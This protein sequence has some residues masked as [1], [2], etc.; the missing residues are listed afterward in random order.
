[1]RRNTTIVA[2]IV[3]LVFSVSVSKAQT[4][5]LSKLKKWIP[6]VSGVIR[7]KFEYNSSIG[8]GRF[9]VRNA[10]FG[11]K[12]TIGK[13]F[14]YKFEIDFSDEGKIKMLDAYVS[15][16]P[17]KNLS[18][19]IGQ[20]K[21]TFSTEYMLSPADFEFSNR[22][23]ID[24]RIC[25][26]LRDIGFRVSYKYEGKVPFEVYGTIM[27]GS[28]FNNPLWTSQ[29]AYGGRAVIGPYK[30][31]SLQANYYSGII[32]NFKTQM[33]D[34]GIRYEYKNFVINSEY[35]QKTISDTIGSYTQNSLFVYTLYRFYFKKGMLRDLVPAVRYDLY[36]SNIRADFTEPQRLTFGLTLGFDKINFANIRFNYEKYLY[37]TLPDLE[38][39]FTV[40]LIARF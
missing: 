39:K 21:A 18:L 11:M 1:M 2:L 9:D 27:N 6:N 28:G 13:Y 26:D 40:E 10:R 17:V 24:K 37:K 25:K 19:T 30:G 22:P 20:M 35:A 33:V 4:D 31:F 34:Y 12:N 15:F 8:K 36:S 16:I 14:G 3:L 5:S 23:F 29:L 38:D 32:V 7:A